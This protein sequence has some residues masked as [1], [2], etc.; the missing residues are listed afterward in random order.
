LVYATEVEDE[1]KL[2]LASALGSVAKEM[3]ARLK[4]TEY[5]P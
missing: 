1:L 5:E 4:L 3:L 2:K